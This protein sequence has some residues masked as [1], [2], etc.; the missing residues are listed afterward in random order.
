MRGWFGDWRAAKPAAAFAAMLGIA[1]GASL[2]ARIFPARAQ[3]AARLPAGQAGAAEPSAAKTAPANG[4]PSGNPAGAAGERKA[5]QAFEAAKANPLELRAFLVRMPKGADLHMHLAGAVYA[6]TWIRE[7]A[8][9]NLCVDPDTNSFFKTE[10][11]TRSLPPQPVCGEGKARASEALEDQH[12]YDTLVDAF[13]M[14]AFAPAAGM[15]GHDH[16]FDSFAKFGAVDHKHIGEW[17]DEVATRAAA[18][19]EEYLE[20]MQ[21]PRFPRTMEIAKEITWNADLPKLRDEILAK[22]FEDD[23]AE[24]RKTFAGAEEE[25]RKLERCGEAEARAACGVKVRFIYQILRGY[26]DEQVFAQTLLGFDVASADPNVVGINMVM[27]EDGRLSM[28]NFEWQMKMLG[29]LHT[30]YPRVHITMHAGE[31]AYGLV[32]PG[33]LCCHVRWAVEWGQAERIG[34]GTDVM[35]EER[36]H[37]LLREMAAKHVMVEINLTSNDVIL[38]VRG[39][40]HPLP[41]YRKWGVP[42]ALSTDDEGVSRI[43]ITNEYARAATTYNLSYADLKTMAR[44]SLEH[45]FLPGESLWARR[46]EFSGAAAACAK[47]GLGSEKPSAGCAEF[48]KKNERAAEQWEL[49]SRFRKFEAGF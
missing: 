44:T 1:A 42:V 46:D 17:V 16:F 13:S 11:M 7:G 31:L 41:I 10:A 27:P 22:G 35:Y 38:G 36:P 9:D 15:S 21:T 3:T 40:D 29:Y 25:R 14:R 23:V 4:R 37:E 20:L 39:K 43:D 48:L 19:N 8:E 26:P 47:D 28:E 33:G 30:V 2:T 24:A 32:P 12:L 6:E 49:E 18:Q 45:S 5:A 34:H